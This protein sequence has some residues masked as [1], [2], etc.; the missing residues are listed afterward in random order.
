M[1]TRIQLQSRSG[2]TID[3]DLALPAGETPAGAVIVVHE[4]FGLNDDIRSHTD[5]LA[6]AGFIALAVDLYRGQVATDAQKAMALVTELQT[7]QAVEDIA[8]AMTYLREQPRA[9]GKIG[10]TGFCVGGAMALA[11]ACQLDGLAAVVPFYG[12]PLPRYADWT[13]VTAAVQGHYGAKDGSI[14]VA[15]VEAVKQALEAAGKSVEIHFYEAGH[16]FMRTG[17]ENYDE[18]SAQAAFE[19]MGGFLRAKLGG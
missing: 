4:W 9:N 3:A 15:K 14:P 8:G 1:T 13:K 5:R 12:L 7:T 17:G 2:E 6:A 10:I 11:A 16:A 19:R 18:A